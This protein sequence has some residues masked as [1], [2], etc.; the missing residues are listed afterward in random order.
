MIDAGSSGSRVHVYAYRDVRPIP[1]FELPSKTL[2]LKPG[3][4]AFEKDPQEAAK[5][6]RGLL[7]FAQANIPL[8]SWTSTPIYLYATAGL[9]NVLAGAAEEILEA[10][11]DLIGSFPFRFERHWARII[12]GRD[13]GVYGW[14]AANYL[15]G[16]LQTSSSSRSDLSTIGVLEMGGA[17]MQVSFVP[18]DTSKFDPTMLTTVSLGGKVY[19][20]YTHSYLNYGLEA[21]QSL[22]AHTDHMK[23]SAS[24]PCYPKGFTFNKQ[25]GSGSFQQCASFIEGILHKKSALCS[26]KRPCSFNGVFQP[27]IDREQFYAIENF[28]Y[29]TEFFGLLETPTF[30]ESLSEKGKAFCEMSWSSIKTAYPKEPEDDLSKYCFSSAYISVMIKHGLGFQ[31][32][33][34]NIKVVK[35]ING[36]AVDWSLGSMLLAIATASIPSHVD[37]R[38]DDSSTPSNLPFLIV[39]VVG[40]VCGAALMTIRPYLVGTTLG[41]KEEA[42]LGGNSMN[43]IG[44]VSSAR[45]LALGDSTPKLIRR[46]NSRVAINIK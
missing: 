29:T 43:G 25:P 39:F 4:S 7:E 36:A 40:A 42:P 20:L 6:I 28:F 23:G 41:P 45:S 32:P 9:R 38:F 27:S 12:S 18:Q 37:P 34:K 46:E 33:E 11:R 13:E 24:N 26:P 5:S 31:S 15:E 21:A 10:V 1:Q 44:S 19:H 30:A 8:E 35:K 17:S 22:L 16:R 2:K 3:L 14:V